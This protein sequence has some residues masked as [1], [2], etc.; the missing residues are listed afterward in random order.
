MQSTT[1][2]PHRVHF[3]SDSYDIF[4]DNCCSKSITN[5]LDDFLE[6][7]RPSNLLI[8]G[9]NGAT[10]TTKV[11]TVQWPL[12]ND[13]GRVHKITLPQTYYS[14]H[15]EHRLL[16]PQHWAQ[17][18]NQGRGTRCITYHDSIL[19]IWGNGK[20]KKTVPLSP[21]N[22]GVMSTPPG[23]Q[24]YLHICRKATCP[25]LGFPTTIHQQ[26][27]TVT[28]SEEEQPSDKVDTPSPMHPL[29][30]QPTE[31]TKTP[32]PQGEPGTQRE[33][34]R[35]TRHNPTTLD[36]QQE[37]MRWHY[38]LNHASQKVMNRMANKGML[39]SYI[40]RILK[41]MD[42]QCRKGPIC[43]DCYS[44]SAARTPCR[45]RPNRQMKQTD[46][47]RASL[48]PGD[49][50]TVDQLETSTPGFI[51]QI[52]GILTR[53]RIVGSTIFVDQAS[54]M[55]YVYHHLSMSSEKT[56]RAKESF[57]R[58]AKSYGVN[59]KHY[60]ADNGRFKNKAFKKSIEDS[61]Q[62]ISFSGVGAHHQNGI[63]EKRI[64][65]VYLYP[66]VAIL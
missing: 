10:A 52:T 46:D 4:A 38:K 9:F 20:Y 65:V 3:D 28:D 29:V 12:Q 55:G 53:Q 61:G 59:I 51:G 19:L 8:K 1:P 31:S 63:A 32:S 36:E 5:C 39:P 50:V 35:H 40:N 58:N 48:S 17:V 60:H 49:V 37:Y 25:L 22:V 34:Q 41:T 13:K 2:T 21:S 43:N 56:V 64:G 26:L 7:P 14:K 6:P 30:D 45:T 47:K 11:G 16:S 27:P 57:K 23:M 44:A 18:A 42:K 66:Q 62:T 15:A 24:S 54:D 33:E